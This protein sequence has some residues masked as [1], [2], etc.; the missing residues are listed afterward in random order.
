MSIASRFH[1]VSAVVSMLAARSAVAQLAT[2]ASAPVPSVITS[3]QRVFISNAGSDSY[4]PVARYSGGP[5][6]FYNELYAGIRSWGR[7]TLTDSPANAE[8][9]YE[10]R[11]TSPVVG[12][13]PRGTSDFVYDPQ[14]NL[15]LLDPQTRVVLWS[16]TEH[17]APART[18]SGD[19]K[20][21]DSAVARILTRVKGLVAGDTAGLAAA[22]ETTSPE[23]LAV[24]RRAAHLQHSALGLIVGGAIGTF[25]A[26]PRAPDCSSV[27]TCSD[28]GH[29][30]LHR[31]VTYTLSAGA[32]GAAIGWLWPTS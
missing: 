18:A 8:V 2:T 28:E 14:L 32:I 16:L 4:L 22:E 5:N 20:N 19:D 13:G 26:H 10:A 24:M 30:S 25:I 15:S 27:V 17:I 7:F 11:F 12:K 29:R 6:R 1:V 31:V 9:V 3:A 21:F 23:M